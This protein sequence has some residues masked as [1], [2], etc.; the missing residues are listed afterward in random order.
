MSLCAVYYASPSSGDAYS[1]RQLTPNFE[2]CVEFFLC[3]DMFPYEDSKTLSVCPYLE[4][5]YHSCFVNISP[6]LVIDTSM[7]RF[8]RVL[9]HRNPKND[10]FFLLLCFVNIFFS[11]YCSHWFVCLLIQSINIH[12]GLNIISVLTTCTFMCRQVAPLIEPSFFNPLWTKLFFSSFF[13]T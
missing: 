1:D 8:S 4:K 5:I 10:F 2:L 13:G 12:V 11:L 6:T 9:Q 7:E 3:A